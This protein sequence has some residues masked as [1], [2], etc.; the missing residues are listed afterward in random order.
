MTDTPPLDVSFPDP[1]ATRTI[2][3]HPIRGALYGLMLGL[4][5]AMWLTL[6]GVIN[7]LDIVPTVI[8]VVAGI[9]IGILWS[10]FAPAKKP[11]SAGAG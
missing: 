5:G 8:V 10:M 3:R 1:S 6:A 11:K 4:G 9:V 2:V 7:L